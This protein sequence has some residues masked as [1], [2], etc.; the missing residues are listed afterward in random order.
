MRLHLTSILQL[1]NPGSGITDWS[2]VSCLAHQV[3]QLGLGS[4]I[5]QTMDATMDDDDTL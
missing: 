3:E 5:I 4:N 1:I 2:D